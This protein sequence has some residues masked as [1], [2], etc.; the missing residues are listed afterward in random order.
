VSLCNAMDNQVSSFG[1]AQFSQ[2]PLSGLTG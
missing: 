1:E 2:G